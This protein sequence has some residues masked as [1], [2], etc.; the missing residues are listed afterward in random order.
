MAPPTHPGP[1]ILRR[2]TS[3]AIT[4]VLVLMLTVVVTAD[5]RMQQDSGA[6]PEPTAER[7]VVNMWDCGLGPDA[8]T[9]TGAVRAAFYSDGALEI[10]GTGKMYDYSE[11]SYA[12]WKDLATSRAITSIKVN[13]G[14][15]SVGDYAF[16][17]CYAV[18]DLVLPESVETIGDY[19]FYHG[20]SL[21]DFSIPSSVKSI[22]DYAYYSCYA[23]RNLVLPDTVETIGDLAFFNCEKITNFDVPDSVRSIGEAAFDQ[24]YSITEIVLP[25]SV[26]SIG[27]YAFA[28]CSRLESVQIGDGA[29]I[30]K[31][32]FYRSGLKSLVMGNDITLEKEAFLE[33]GGV[34]TVVMGDNIIMGKSAFS[35]N[36]SLESVVMGDNISIGECAFFNELSPCDSLKNLRMGDHVSIGESAFKKCRGLREVVFGNDLT[37]ASSAFDPYGF[38]NEDSTQVLDITS[39]QDF[40]GR[41]FE[42][43]QY[44]YVMK[45]LPGCTI[46]FDPN[47]GTSPT[48][49]VE[50][51][52]DGMLSDSDIPTVTRPGCSFIGWFTDPTDGDEVD[53]SARFESGTILYAHWTQKCTV[54]YDHSA[55]RALLAE[56]RYSEDHM[57]GL[58]TGPEGSEAYDS[59]GEVAEF[60]HV[61]WIVDGVQYPATQLFVET[62][63]HTAR[64][65]WVGLPA[66][67]YDHSRLI[68][69][70]GD[71]G[72]VAGLNNAI[73][74]KGHYN[75]EQLPARDGY[76]HVGWLIG[77]VE[78]GPTDEFVTRNSH[79]AISLWTAIPMVV[80]DHHGLTD[81]VGGGAE[82]VSGLPSG[83][84]ISENTRYVQ[85][86]DTAGYRHIGW[87]IGDVTVGPTAKFLSTE[88]HTA[89]SLWEEITNNGFVPTPDDGRWDDGIYIPEQKGSEQGWLGD[90]KN[91]LIVAILAVIIA[92]LAVLQISR[93][94]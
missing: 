19:A 20:Y 36:R 40:E 45:R 56:Y 62:T 16:Y 88:T 67:T 55:L 61:G 53:P 72:S 34:R 71:S 30:G 44:Y 60:K 70:T 89:V 84:I 86:P 82:G 1:R 26:E 92:E 24:C 11:S 74:I 87:R 83:L 23:V 32:A 42:S 10:T 3:I 8:S 69:A 21:Q 48:I 37:M 64:S 79:T 93:H 73:E 68:E 38:T 50:T 13:E 5:I 51:D 66:V 35:S 12:P 75:Y 54:T 94:K 81:I 77:D 25:D 14:V 41:T 2:K 18:S 9:P 6:D 78:V 22:G 49:K 17:G 57:I 90:S 58:P 59:L 31:Q 80:L 52:A 7:T 63:D 28:Y 4:L 39:M 43:P 29:S 91:L 85:L 46:S 76:M 47:D 33:A 15:T 65:V 27:D